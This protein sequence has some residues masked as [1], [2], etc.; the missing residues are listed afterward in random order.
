MILGRFASDIAFL[1]PTMTPVL[2]SLYNRCALTSDVHCT[3]FHEKTCLWRC[4]YCVKKLQWWLIHKRNNLAILWK[5]VGRPVNFDTDLRAIVSNNPSFERYYNNMKFIFH[6]IK[7]F[8]CYRLSNTFSL[9]FLLSIL[10]QVGSKWIDW[11][12]LKI[13]PSIHT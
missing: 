9:T 7:R 12:N 1:V 6:E 10:H 13:R 2:K 5:M 4:E 3:A 11:G 8:F